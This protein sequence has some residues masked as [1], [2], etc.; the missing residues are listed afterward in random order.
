MMK[1]WGGRFQK[2]TARAVEEFTASINFDRRLYYHDIIGSIAHSRM[3]AKQGII[4]PQEADYIARGLAEIAAEIAAD[5]FPWRIELEDVHMNVEARLRE[6]IGEVAGKLHTA[7]SRNDQIALDMR[8]FTR[9]AILETV[10]KLI[11]F[12]HTLVAVAGSNIDVVMPGYTH[13]QRAQPVLLAHHLL[14]YFEMLQRDVERLMG[15]YTRCNIS[16]LGAGAIAGTTFPI[17]RAAVAE[18]LGFAEVSRNS[19]DSVSDR[20][21]VV[22]YSSAASLIM[23]HLS[24][25][26]EEVIL[27]S[28]GEFGFAELDDAYSTGSS[29]MPQKKNPDI[30]EL[31]R[32]KTGRVYG[33]L[34]AILTLLKGLPLTYNR[35]LQEDKEGLFDTVDTVITSL[36]V[37]EGMIKTTRFRADRMR[38]IASA[39]FALATDVADY[40][41]RRDL[42]FRQ[43]HEVVGKLV[44]YCLDANKDFAQLTL[45][46]YQSH[47][48][49][50]QD[51]VFHI[52]VDS[53]VA[54]R[55]VPGGTAPARVRNALAAATN[56]IQLNRVWLQQKPRCEDLGLLPPQ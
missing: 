23:M 32:G 20:D 19:M 43:A 33:H 36:G 12:Q 42:P 37:F 34:H 53:S 45:A 51:D 35:D 55:A 14:A 50:F 6:K 48:P 28:S 8:L 4:A 38:E 5:Q 25:F 39:S 10:E 7:R 46:E 40:L 54:A 21:F 22:E 17:D 18:A 27:W 49:L 15:A 24:R 16:P 11:A 56:T 29:M 44:A 31:A 30:A 1:L 3:L 47:S 2:S 9:D 41:V 26:A 52:T 13:V